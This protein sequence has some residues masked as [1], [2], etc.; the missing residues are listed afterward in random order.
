M[1]EKQYYNEKN[2]VLNYKQL[3]PREISVDKGDILDDSIKGDKVR[4]LCPLELSIK[5][6]IFEEDEYIV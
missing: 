5:F 6:L 1:I 4:K 2:V 3:L